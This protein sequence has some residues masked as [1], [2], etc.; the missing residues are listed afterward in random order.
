MNWNIFPEKGLYYMI[1]NKEPLPK[2]SDNELLDCL[3][4]KLE[5]EALFREHLYREK[6]EYVVVV[7]E[8][9]KQSFHSKQIKILSE[10][11][12]SILKI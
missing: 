7:L 3:R 1:E 6:L 10:E 9:T 5:C 12:E 11:I 4:K 2:L 8:K